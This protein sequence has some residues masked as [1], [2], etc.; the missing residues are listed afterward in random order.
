MPRQAPFSQ[1]VLP[2]AEKKVKS[3]LNQHNVNIQ[4]LPLF[5]FAAFNPNHHELKLQMEYAIIG[6]ALSFSLCICVKYVYFVYANRNFFTAFRVSS[7]LAG[8][9]ERAARF[10]QIKFFGFVA[11]YARNTRIMCACIS[12]RISTRTNN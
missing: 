11:N 1:F 12:N 9:C 7:T 4:I 8:F 3:L 5:P 6:L 10:L 2:H